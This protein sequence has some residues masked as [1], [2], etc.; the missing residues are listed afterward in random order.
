[1]G[2]ADRLDRDP[3]GGF[4]KLGEVGDHLVVTDRAVADAEAEHIFGRRN[5]VVVRCCVQLV[6]FDR[7]SWADAAV[8]A[9]NAPARAV[10]RAMISPHHRV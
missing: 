7:F 9:A 8:S 6:E 10:S 4:G 2:I 1:M 5:A 3:V